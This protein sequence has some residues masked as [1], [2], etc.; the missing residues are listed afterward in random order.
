MTLRFACVA[1]AGALFL[2]ESPVPAQAPVPPGPAAATRPAQRKPKLFSPQDLGLL[3]AP[4]RDDWNKPDLVMDALGIADGAVVADLGAGGGWLTLRLARRVGPNGLVYAEDVQPQMIEAMSRRLQHEGIA[5]VRTVLGKVTD[6]LLP[7]GLDAVILMN[8]YREMDDPAKP[9]VILTLLE[10]IAR[11]LA[12]GPSRRRRLSPG[13]RWAGPAAEDRVNP[14]TVIK[15]AE[16]AG[17][18]LQSR[19]DIPPFQFILVFT[20][21]APPRRAS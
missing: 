15:S 8:A 13:E 2:L 19:E 20:R 1:I 17:L 6:P 12:A 16:A 18:F 21:S 3:E 5:Q 7:E 11:S 14:E 4:D 10:N 9:E